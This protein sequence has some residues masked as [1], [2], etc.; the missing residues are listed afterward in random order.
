MPCCH[1]AAGP[2]MGVGLTWEGG[3][4]LPGQT[5]SPI[6]HS[7]KKSPDAITSSHDA[8]V[9]PFPVLAR[10]PPSQAR[11]NSARMKVQEEEGQQQEEAKHEDAPGG[12]DVR[13]VGHAMVRCFFTGFVIRIVRD[14]ILYKTL[15]LEDKAGTASSFLRGRV[16]LLFVS[17]IV[18]YLPGLMAEDTSAPPEGCVENVMCTRHAGGCGGVKLLVML[19]EEGEVAV[20][21]RAAGHGPQRR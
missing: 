7:L 14:E 3:S 2:S 4:E 6:V 18:H 21:V 16:H 8:E 15:V 11:S 5:R 1:G 10:T 20:Q 17:E 9:L 13:W 12:Q 19:G